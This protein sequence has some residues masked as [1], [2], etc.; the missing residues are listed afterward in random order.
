MEN[1]TVARSSISFVI[2][3]LNEQETLPIVLEKIN[4]VC[5]TEFKDRITEIVVSDN[6]S[7]D[8][9]QK[10]SETNGAK[11]VH[12]KERGYGAALQC[13]INNAANDIVV[14]ADADNTYDFLETPRLINELDKGYD[15]VLGSRL[16]GNIHPGAMP[17]L[18]RYLGT[19]V[20][21]FLINLLYVKN[22]Y[23]ITDCN[24]GF[25]CF[26]REKFLS[27]N[28]KGSGME[29][30]SEMLTKSL[31]A[32]AKISQVPISLYPDTGS[33]IPHLK[34]WRDGMRHFLQIFLEAPDFFYHAGLIA[35]IFSWVVMLT[36]F[37]FG[38]VKLGFAS[39][40]GIH[41]M[42]FA[43]L[44]SIFAIII[45]AIGLFLTVNIS[46]DIKIYK[47]LINISEDKL[48]WYTLLFISI[49][50]ALF[51]VIIINWAQQGFNFLS[52]EK[53]T[54]VVIA[55]ASNGMLIVFNVNTTHLLKRS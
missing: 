46:T 55:L 31:K 20:L 28:V 33:R 25:R 21:N 22:G 45:W 39:V 49:C 41:T 32:E 9:S 7:K 29:F 19:P 16:Q 37:I 42:M 26:K 6:G 54:L 15:L 12:C 1:K 23:K 44:L 35:F 10:I 8:N 5:D 17:L 14:F 40:L 47:Y 53:L 11:I 51:V 34:T 27:W 18:H 30:A 4:K 13:G 2:P 3:C 52:L 48:F 24:S 38:P 50:A 36:G 43:F